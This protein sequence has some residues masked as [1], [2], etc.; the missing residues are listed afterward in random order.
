MKNMNLSARVREHVRVLEAFFE[1]QGDA[2]VQLSGRVAQAMSDGHKLLL[3]GNGGSAAD[4]QHIAAEFTNRFRLERPPLPALALTTDTSALTAVAND[5][6]YDQVFVKQVK[7][8]GQSGDVLVGIST[9]GNSPSVVKAI[10]AARE[11]GLYSVA[12]TGGSG[13]AAGATA[14]LHLCVNATTD[15][16]LIQEVHI[17]ALHVMC[18]LVDEHLFPS[19]RNSE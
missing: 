13:G 3:C 12:L 14:D 5:Y 17:T 9:S 6:G 10:E 15:T 11:R 16:A 19:L 1:T 7:A 4:S 2:L 18:Q 8:L